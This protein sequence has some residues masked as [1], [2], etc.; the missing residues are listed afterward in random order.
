M[1][2]QLDCIDLPSFT[3]IKFTGLVIFKLD[4]LLIR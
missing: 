2:S 4:L 3:K 1:K